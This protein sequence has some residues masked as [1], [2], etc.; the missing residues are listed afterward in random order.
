MGKEQLKGLGGW[1]II[2]IIGLFFSIPILIYDLTF[3]NIASKFWFLEGFSSLLYLILLIFTLIAL[4][5]IFNKKKFVPKL[6]IYFY[7]INIVIH[8][9]I[10]FT[11]Q[12][13]SRIAPPIVGGIIWGSYFIRSK[14][15][16]NTFVN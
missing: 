6:M 2:P 10:A 9:I 8:L 1:L 11:I 5:L 4:F 7:I 15:V 12:D 3:V 13:F 16:K 14:R